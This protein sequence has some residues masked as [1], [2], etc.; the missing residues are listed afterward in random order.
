MILVL[1]IAAVVW[2]ALS[3][4]RV[5]SPTRAAGIAAA[6]G[7]GQTGRAAA[8]DRWA[9]GAGGRATRRKQRSK[10]RAGRAVNA[11]GTGLAGLG[12]ILLG[13]TG[14][15]GAAAAG[16]A[17]AAGYE[18]ADA[19]ELHRWRRRQHGNRNDTIARVILDT[20]T[21]FGQAQPLMQRLQDYL[22]DL[23][24][25]LRPGARNERGCGGCGRRTVDVIHPES[26]QTLCWGC[27]RR[28]A[29]AGDIDPADYD[30]LTGADRYRQPTPTD[31]DQPTPEPAGGPQPAK[32][33]EPQA[34][35][36]EKP[37]EP[38]PEEQ[39]L[40]AH[41]ETPPT[42]PTAPAPDATAE[43]I[44]QYERD[45][46]R[47]EAEKAKWELARER[48]RAARDAAVAARAAAMRA[49]TAAAAARLAAAAAGVQD[50]PVDALL[51]GLATASPEEAAQ[52]LA[53]APDDVVARALA[54]Q[55]ASQN[56]LPAGEGST[57]DALENTVMPSNAPTTLDVPNA[58]AL[59]VVAQ[60]FAQAA[61]AAS[62]I[63]A[64]AMT[65]QNLPDALTY[66]PGRPV[67]AVIMTLAE[68]APDPKKLGE[69]AETLP[70]LLKE[71]NAQLNRNEHMATDQL[72][73]EAQA[74]TT[75]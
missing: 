4:D 19:R 22:R 32:P 26:G 63:Q 5:A 52:L 57:T 23:P 3:P 35:Q 70:V 15:A 42:P 68:L 56:S 55:D 29:R 21:P 1:I 64:I 14:T 27:Y 60:A 40:Q 13:A 17:R 11:T 34:N 59:M 7:A 50:P 62:Q 74:H 53:S 58:D 67:L 48:L 18:F 33:A 54:W 45:Q 69:F 46:A 72:T 47:H 73:G 44:A 61:E 6:R 71:L 39:A 75:S 43:Q 65:A 25:L 36:Q 66:G 31:T 41:E 12:R 8:A 49:R 28:Q 2:V 37:A 24:S 10:T 20:I 9:Q 51:A 16:A 38:T 30:F